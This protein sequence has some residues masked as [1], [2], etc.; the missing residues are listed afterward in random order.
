MWNREK[1]TEGKL[2]ILAL[3]AT[4]ALELFLFLI[5]LR[6]H[7]AAPILLLSEHLHI[8]SHVP[9]MLPDH[10]LATGEPIND[11]SLQL[12]VLFA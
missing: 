7:R 5:I 6:S 9:L 1:V 8:L 3:T 12:K 2:L 4:R 10:G 11:H